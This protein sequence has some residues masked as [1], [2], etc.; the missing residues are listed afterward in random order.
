MYLKLPPPI[1]PEI[2][3]RLPRREERHLKHRPVMTRRGAPLPSGTRSVRSTSCSTRVK[4]SAGRSPPT[5]EEEDPD[6]AHSKKVFLRE[7]QQKQA[8]AAVSYHDS[9]GTIIRQT[10]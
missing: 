5:R 10:K 9:A 1:L 2:H 7:E 6:E 4:S 3:S 8:E